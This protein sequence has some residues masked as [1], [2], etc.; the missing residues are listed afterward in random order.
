VLITDYSSLMVDFASTG[1]PLLLFTYDLEAYGSQIRG[2]NVDLAE[3]A[4]GPLLRTTDELAEALR[5][6]EGVHA[7]YARRYENFVARFCEL[8]DGHATARV[9]DRIFGP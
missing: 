5:D 8:D 6:L 1:R 3:I 2:L 9:V 7:D 4:P